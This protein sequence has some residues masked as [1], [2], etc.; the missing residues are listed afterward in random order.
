MT[1][2]QELGIT[3]FP[4]EEF[5][6]AGNRTYYE[7]ASGYWQKADYDSD[8]YLIDYEDTNEK[9]VILTDDDSIMS[10]VEDDVEVHEI[11]LPQPSALG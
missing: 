10:F 6:D 1:K 5:D 3:E 8:G 11:E 2:A 4:Y 7:D 9:W